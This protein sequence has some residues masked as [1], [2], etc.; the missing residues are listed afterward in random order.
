MIE[1]VT[2]APFKSVE[3]TKYCLQTKKAHFM[4]IF[5]EVIR[6]YRVM[7]IRSWNLVLTSWFENTDI[8]QKKSCVV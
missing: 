8:S 2:E 3:W 7:H 4:I 6:P 5:L 1:Y